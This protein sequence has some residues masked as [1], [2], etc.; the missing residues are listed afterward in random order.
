MRSRIDRHREE[1]PFVPSVV[2]QKINFRIPPTFPGEPTKDDQDT[3]NDDDNNAYLEGFFAKIAQSLKIRFAIQAITGKTSAVQTHCQYF[4]KNDSA[5]SGQTTLT[6][7]VL[8][9]VCTV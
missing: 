1:N 3:C 8:S 4:P 5:V 9:K 2:W 7:M 6:P